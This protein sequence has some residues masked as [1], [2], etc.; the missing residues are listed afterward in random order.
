[1]EFYKAFKMKT[2]STSEGGFR[3]SLCSVE[4][5]EENGELVE[6]DVGYNG[7]GVDS[8]GLKKD[9]IELEVYATA[10]R[11]LECATVCGYPYFYKVM[12]PADAVIEENAEH[13]YTVA[14][15]LRFVRELSF[16]DMMA[17]AAKEENSGA[18]CE[19]ESECGDTEGKYDSKESMAVV[20]QGLIERCEKKIFD[21]VKHK[22]LLSVQ[23]EALNLAQAD[24]EKKEKKRME[25]IARVERENSRLRFEAAEHKRA[26]PLW[27]GSAA[28]I[29]MV[30]GYFIGLIV[31]VIA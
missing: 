21:I 28:V 12:V 20:V 23:E 22:A 8:E 3:F 13:G 1:M 11:C 17:I 14:K 16:D 9:G 7:D 15:E 26:F 30:V 10:K 18:V 27:L 5:Y 31:G 4:C 6:V 24:A 25:H 29:S 2:D 19:G